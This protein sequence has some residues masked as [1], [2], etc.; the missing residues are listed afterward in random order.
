TLAAGMIDDTMG[1][2][3]LSVVAGLASSG[4]VSLGSAGQAILSVVAVFGLAFTV[5][6]RFVRW[7]IRWLDNAV[8]GDMVLITGLML[9]ALAFGSLTHLL[10]LEA[11]LGAFIAGILV[12]EVRRF[13]HRLRHIFEQLTLG[14][15]APVF[16]ALSGI[17]VNLAALLDPTVLV[18]AVVVLAV[19]ILGK[20]VGAYAGA[21]A[22]RMGNWEALALGSG[23]NARG[24]IEI[25]VATIGLSLGI[26]TPSMYTIILMIS[27]VTSLMAPPLLRW[28]LRHVEFSEEE[29]ERLEAEERRRDSF[30]GNLKRVLLPTR[31]GANSQIA[32]Q[33]VGL[34]IHDEDIEVTSMFVRPSGNGQ[35]RTSDD[36]IQTRLQ[37]I[38]AHLE[39]LEPHNMRSIVREAQD[40][41]ST[42]VLGEADRG[43]DLLVIG[44]TERR[45]DGQGS[46]FTEFVD[47]VIQES[48]C[49][50]L[51]VSARGDED[52]DESAEPIRLQHILVP[53]SG[54][55]YDRYAAEAAFSIARDR[56]IVVDLLHVVSGPQHATRVG[57]DEAMMEAVELGEDL[58]NKVADLGHSMGATV[59]TDVVVADQPENAIVER[60]QRR[61]DLVVLASNRRPVSQRAFF[62]HRIDHVLRQAACP[63]AVVSA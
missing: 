39:P 21:K 56:E 59:H 11:V 10:H 63:V 13:D 7:V 19:A 27:I 51:V 4:T 46:L 1:W 34:M 8:G 58:V 47:D 32:A 55:D 22:S 28:T 40:G 52:S 31:G 43:Y 60:A 17:R 45:V 37:R 26:L 35:G 50:V 29:K 14:V 25:I 20:F 36:E 15:F 24:A 30:V 6:R 33:L 23:M 61:A 12:G 42:S 44:A 9:L 54:S 16:F 53:V 41:V 57:G 48:P 2:V 18:V 5:G 3:L 62:G 38:E 49:P